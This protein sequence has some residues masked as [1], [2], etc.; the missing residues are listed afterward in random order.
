MDETEAER[1]AH[2]GRAPAATDPAEGAS[3]GDDDG[4][5]RPAAKVAAAAAALRATAADGE[6]VL[7]AAP[8]ASCFAL[9]LAAIIAA[10]GPSD[11]AA[12]PADERSVV[13]D[14]APS[15]IEEAVPY[16]DARVALALLAVAVDAVVLGPPAEEERHRSTFI[17]DCELHR[18]RV[19]L[20]RLPRPTLERLSSF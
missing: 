16:V 12:V 3:G 1:G 15:R 4:P 5:L 18:L 7:P 6:E 11:S 20:R 2:S 9:R 8:S 19:G 14:V 13:V 17:P 10:R